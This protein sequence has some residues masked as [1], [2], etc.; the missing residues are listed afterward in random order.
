MTGQLGLEQGMATFL[1]CGNVRS[2]VCD[3]NRKAAGGSLALKERGRA[4]PA[5]QKTDLVERE[6]IGIGVVK[7]R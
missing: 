6:D 5:A 4:G 3:E 2:F 7:V 1:L